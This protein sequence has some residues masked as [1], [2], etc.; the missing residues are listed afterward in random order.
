MDKKIKKKFSL[1]I[2]IILAV[3]LVFTGC[4]KTTQADVDRQGVRWLARLA[5]K[6]VD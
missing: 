2:F 6:Y 3:A 5:I 1:I 4:Q